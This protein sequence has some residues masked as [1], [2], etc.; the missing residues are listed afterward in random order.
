MV[1]RGTRQRWGAWL[2]LVRPAY[3]LVELVVAAAAVRYSFVDD[4][5]SDLGAVTTSPWHPLM[6]AAFVVFGVFMGLG[7]VLQA[8]RFGPAVTI[9]LVI[10]GLSSAAVGLTPLDV[11]P[12]LHVAV[13]TPVFVAQPLAL[14]LL[15]RATRA[16]ALVVA[17]VVS[18]VAAIGFIL[19]D[20]PHGT[21]VLERVAL[22]PTFVALAVVAFRELAP[23][24]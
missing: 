1:G 3:F 6:N 22:W 18:S 20:L 21:G 19:L 9:L 17:G 16:P 14:V 10:S 24:R 4:T 12:A 7:A 2:W 5:I 15:G 13:A 11:H 23:R 8:G